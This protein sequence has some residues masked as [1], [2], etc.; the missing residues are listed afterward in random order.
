MT[1]RQKETLATKTVAQDKTEVEIKQ[2][3]LLKATGGTVY[4]A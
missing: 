4:V 1:Q 3:D 2:A